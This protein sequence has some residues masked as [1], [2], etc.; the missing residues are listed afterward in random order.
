MG[1]GIKTL[2]DMS[3]ESIVD[4]LPIVVVSLDCELDTKKMIGMLLRL[5]TFKD[6]I[7]R[8]LTSCKITMEMQFSK[9]HPPLFKLRHLA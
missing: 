8:I 3:K 9:I 4:D 7:F 5:S 6:I 2:E 1:L